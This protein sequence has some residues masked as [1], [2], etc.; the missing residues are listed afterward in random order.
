MFCCFV[1]LL[2]CFLFP[3]LVVVVVVVV[4]MV[5]MVVVLLLVMVMMVVVVVAAASTATRPTPVE[6]D[7]TCSREGNPPGSLW[8]PPGTTRRRGGHVS[9]PVDRF[10]A[11]AANSWK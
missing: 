11:H 4:M 1:V 6:R 7:R 10:R 3:L 5:V 2:F 9:S 8:N